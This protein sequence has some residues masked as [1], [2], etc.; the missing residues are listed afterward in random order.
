MIRH[1][2]AELPASIFIYSTTKNK[3]DTKNTGLTTIN[4]LLRTRTYQKNIHLP[5]FKVDEN[6]LLAKYT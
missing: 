2:G 4:I 1:N 5:C 6:R 3:Q